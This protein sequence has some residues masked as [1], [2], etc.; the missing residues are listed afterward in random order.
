[1]QMKQSIDIQVEESWM[2]DHSGET[3]EMGSCC[4]L[5]RLTNKSLDYRV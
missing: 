3:M 1:M 2:E 5:A 4:E